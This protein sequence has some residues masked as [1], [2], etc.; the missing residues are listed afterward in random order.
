M[1][2]ALI[3]CATAAGLIRIS[4]HPQLPLPLDSDTA[5]LTNPTTDQ[6]ASVDRFPE[7]SRDA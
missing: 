1:A 2:I 4:R 3:I 5:T 7:R 6:S